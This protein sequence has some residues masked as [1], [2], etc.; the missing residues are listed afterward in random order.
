M[1]KEEFKLILV[2]APTHRYFFD[3]FMKEKTKGAKDFVVK[4]NSFILDNVKYVRVGYNK[5]DLR[6]YFPDEIIFDEFVDHDLYTEALSR[7]KPR[8]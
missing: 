3:E 5:E 6:G 1:K 8:T 7:L 2:F 4:N